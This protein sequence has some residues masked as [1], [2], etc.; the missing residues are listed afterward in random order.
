MNAIKDFNSP[1]FSFLSNRFPYNTDNVY[2]IYIEFEGLVFTSV[3][4]AYQAAKTRDFTIRQKLQKMSPLEVRE[5]AVAKQ[6]KLRSDWEEIREKVMR[7]LV[8]QKF[9]GNKELREKL[10]STGDAELIKENDEGD[11]YWG[12][13]NGEGENRIGKIL[14]D[15]RKKLRNINW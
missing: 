4:A 6:L 14:M 2:A 15:V 9:Y 1:E 12:M 8:W 5:Y 11:T 3:E 7:N 13:C 10:L